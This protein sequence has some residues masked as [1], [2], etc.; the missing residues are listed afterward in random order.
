M[1]GAEKSTSFK[2]VNFAATPCVVNYGTGSETM[3]TVA[4]EAGHSWDGDVQD[5]SNGRIFTFDAKD[6]EYCRDVW[7]KAFNNHIAYGQSLSAEEKDN[8]KAEAAIVGNSGSS[9]DEVQV[10]SASVEEAVY[11]VTNAQNGKA[12]SV[13]PDMQVPELIDYEEQPESLWKLTHNADGSYVL[14]NVHRD[15]ALAATNEK[16]VQVSPDKADTNW[17][18]SREPNGAYVLTHR[19]HGLPLS[20]EGNDT[21]TGK[22]AL[23]ERATLASHWFLSKVARDSVER[24]RKTFVVKPCDTHG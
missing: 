16:V 21:E 20:A 1:Y 5:K 13:L 23:A 17:L 19:G 8:M 10:L 4:P 6:S 18:L 15:F 12:L 11:T 14:R 9:D 7:M 22:L 2:T 24:I 3:F